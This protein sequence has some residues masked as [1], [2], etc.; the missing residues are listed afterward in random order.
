MVITGPVG[1]IDGDGLP[2]VEVP[3][4]LLDEDLAWLARF[5]LGRKV[6]RVPPQVPITPDPRISQRAWR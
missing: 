6:R 4:E 2:V 1:P 3:Q 5:T